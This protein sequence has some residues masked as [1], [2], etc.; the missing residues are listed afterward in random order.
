ME[1]FLHNLKS[2]TIYNCYNSELI[3]RA[4]IF[5]CSYNK[6]QKH[7]NL[8]YKSPEQFGKQLIKSV[9]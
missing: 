1:S 6:K 7:E 3:V 2:E 4:K 9:A 5:E 8:D